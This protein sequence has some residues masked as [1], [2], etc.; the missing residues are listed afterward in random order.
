MELKNLLENQI[1]L[2][3][4]FLPVGVMALGLVVLLMS[5]LTALKTRYPNA[6]AWI[7]IVFFS[8]GPLF[9]EPLSVLEAKGSFNILLS[10]SALVF[11]LQNWSLTDKSRQNSEYYALVGSIFIG[12]YVLLNTSHFLV[13]IIGL[14]LMSIPAYLLTCWNTKKSSYEAGLKYFIY[15]GFSTAVLLYGVSWWYGATG[16]LELGSIEVLVVALNQSSTPFVLM[17]AGCIVIGLAYKIAAF[18]MHFWSPDAY[19]EAPTPVVG[20][21]AVVPKIAGFVFLEKL[22]LVLMGTTHWQSVQKIYLL[23]AVLSLLLGNLAALKQNKAKRMMA[24]SSIAHTGFMLFPL[25]H[26]S[27]SNLSYFHF[28]LVL[29]AFMNMALFLFLDYYERKFDVS[30]LVDFKGLG[31]KSVFMG[32]LLLILLIS[33]TGLPP[34]GGFIAK[35]LIFT[36][37]YEG[38]VQSG[39]LIFLFI[40]I[41]A[42]INTVIAL[43]YYLKIPYFMFMKKEAVVKKINPK[44]FLVVNFLGFILVFLITVSF[45]M[46]T[47]L[48]GIINNVNFVQ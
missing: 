24:Y 16:F 22:T 45:F 37:M 41:L 44:S 4:D 7:F 5:E 30:S 32:V 14:E 36:G 33:L 42:G 34:T 38:L 9:V 39:D 31:S 35:L 3:K 25:L 11:G 21:F 18:P 40:L 6:F 20:L 19:Q 1:V 2:L 8:V 12:A 47:W 48:M 10:L 46:P 13:A 29:Y 26:A 27:E 17:T 43:F 28:Y 23:L 15:G